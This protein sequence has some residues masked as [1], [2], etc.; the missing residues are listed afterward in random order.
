MA[1]ERFAESITTICCEPV[2]NMEE[3]TCSGSLDPVPAELGAPEDWL[4][5]LIHPKATMAMPRTVLFSRWNCILVAF[6]S[7]LTGDGMDS[8]SL[9]VRFACRKTESARQERVSE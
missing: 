1:I 7:A 2:A 9:V 4:H 5:R 6:A 3:N 8:D